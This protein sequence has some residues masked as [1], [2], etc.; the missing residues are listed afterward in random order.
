VF[1]RL[2]GEPVTLVGGG[3]VAAG[4]LAGL[5]D[6][7]ARVTVVAP[8]VLPELVRPGVR[9]VVRTFRDEDLDGAR[10]V[11][12][13]APPAVNRAVADAARTRNLFVNAVDDVDSATAFLGGVIRRGEVTVA[14]STGGA[15][16]ALAGLVRQA[17]DAVLPSSDDLDQWVATARRLRAA[18]KREHVPIDQRRAR[19]LEAL[20]PPAPPAR[21]GGGSREARALGVPPETSRIHGAGS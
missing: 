3:R 1:L 7:G 6:A 2:E 5:L 21:S 15:A 20:R 18:W 8:H 14:I 12:A 19:L 11:I 9:V 16:P 4:K 13:A 10:F 17:L